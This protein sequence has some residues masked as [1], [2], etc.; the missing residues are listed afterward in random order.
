M[1]EFNVTDSSNRMETAVAQ[2]SKDYQGCSESNANVIACFK[3]QLQSF[4]VH[5]GVNCGL[6][7]KLSASQ[8]A[9]ESLREKIGSIEPS[10]SALRTTFQ[11]IETKEVGLV[12]QIEEICRVMS[13]VKNSGTCSGSENGIYATTT[14][15]LVSQLEKVSHELGVAQG[16]LRAKD[17]ENEHSKCLLFETTNILQETQARA[18][19]HASENAAL[20]EKVRATE[21]RI[22]EEL[23][24]ASVISRDQS[25]AKFEQQLH[26]ILR[27]K[28]AIEHD[29]QT[30]KELLARAQQSQVKHI[31]FTHIRTV[32]DA[33]QLQDDVLAEQL[34][35]EMEPLV[36]GPQMKSTKAANLNS[37]WLKKKRSRTSKTAPTRTHLNTLHKRQI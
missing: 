18:A 29:L 22:R 15:D 25:R 37:S 14:A 9:C 28:T 30:A 11:G 12:E 34:R 10:L 7:K 23:N 3:E 13:E 5:L 33:Q 21:S 20:Q 6:S 24:R 26:G 8:K 16:A 27:E 35:K 19:Q 2:M 32:A 36:C 17:D 31:I 1:N 4:E